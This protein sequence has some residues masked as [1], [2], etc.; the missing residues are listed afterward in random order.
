MISVKNHI[1][2]N[3][4]CRA[5]QNFLGLVQVYDLLYGND[6]HLFNNKKE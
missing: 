3:K 5:I 2:S 4:G 6:I 1:P